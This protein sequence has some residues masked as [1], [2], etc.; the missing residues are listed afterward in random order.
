MI[1][2]SASPDGGSENIGI[3]PIVVAELKLRDV[4]QPLEKLDSAD[5]ERIGNT[6]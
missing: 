1:F 5:S 6:W 4:E 3:E 2:N